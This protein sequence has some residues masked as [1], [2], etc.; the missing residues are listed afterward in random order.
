MKCKITY[1]GAGPNPSIHISKKDR[2]NFFSRDNKTISIEVNDVEGY[3]T[4]QNDFFGNVGQIRTIYPTKEYWGRNL[5]IDW[6]R[7]NKL[8]PGDEI[9]LEVIVPC[10]KF[11]LKRI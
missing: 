11:R 10:K 4:L 3:T 6:I 1:H 2:K 9:E 8:K 7:E 5:L